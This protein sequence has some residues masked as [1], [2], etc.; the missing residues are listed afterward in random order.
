RL[1]EQGLIVE[2]A[3][4]EVA[5]GQDERRRHYRLTPAGRRAAPR[6]LAR[7][8]ELVNLGRRAGLSPRRT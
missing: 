3:D 6:E 5:S 7:L 1:L 2:L 8:G 4:R